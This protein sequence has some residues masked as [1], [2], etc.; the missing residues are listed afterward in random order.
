MLT[1][2]FHSATGA[3]HLVSALAAMA[4]GAAVLL[5]TKGTLTHK[6]VG[7]AYVSAMIL[8]NGSAFMLYHMFGKFGPFHV[9]ALVSGTAIA[10]GMLP[11]LFRRYVGGWLY[12]HYYFMNW[13]VVG[14]YAA[15]W[16]ETLVRLFPM[17]QFWPVVIVA[18]LGTTA[19]GSYLIRRYR[20]KFFGAEKAV[21]TAQPNLTA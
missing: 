8:V 7:Y 10:G 15:F 20:S 12:F 18:T 3:V 16:A 21:A 5:T 9:A 17:K 2:F 4:L 14:L 1:A 6:R 19:L 13:S 11:I